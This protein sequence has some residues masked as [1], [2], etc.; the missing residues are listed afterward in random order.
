VGD[1]TA[2]VADTGGESFTLSSDSA[3]IVDAVGT[4]LRDANSDVEIRLRRNGDFAGLVKRIEPDCH[5]GVNV[6]DERTFQVTFSRSWFRDPEAD[7]VFSLRLEVVA[8]GVAT[9]RE[10][11]VT[12]RIGP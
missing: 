11:P 10:I 5:S 8:E 6:G 12:V 1:V 4:A 9:I 2:I 3:E 7:H